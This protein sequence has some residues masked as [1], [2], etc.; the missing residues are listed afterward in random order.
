MKFYSQLNEKE[1]GIA[2]DILFVVIIFVLLA[3]IDLELAIFVTV[4][5]A[6]VL[7]IR[8]IILQ[9]NP[10]HGKNKKVIYNGKQLSVPQ[11]TEIFEL[12]DYASFEK[13]NKYAEALRFISL[14]PTILIIRFYRQIQ[15]DKASAVIMSKVVKRLSEME[16][17]T[18]FSDI[19]VTI[20]NQ[21]E[22][23]DILHIIGGEN[24]FSSIED[25]L[26]V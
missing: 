15:I 8:R 4:I 22:Y 6:A 11:N 20:F 23:H 1:K 21:L 16:V 26:K 2:K 10:D 7:I 3:L 12:K 5:C 24:L 14:P 25:A 17:R 13:L 9:L 18:V 19:D